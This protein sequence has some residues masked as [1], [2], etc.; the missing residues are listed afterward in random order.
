MGDRAVVH[1]H[2]DSKTLSPATYLHWG[3]SEVPALLAEACKIMAGRTGD[4]DYTMARFV[5][6]CHN[7]IDGNLSLGVF[8]GAATFEEAK[9]DSYTHGDSGVWLVNVE[10]EIWNVEVVGGYGFGDEF[11]PFGTIYPDDRGAVPGEHGEGEAD[12]G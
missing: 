2:T 8:R 4:R 10:R 6:V 12:Q 5:G 1:F 3:G 9:E 11:E 7:A